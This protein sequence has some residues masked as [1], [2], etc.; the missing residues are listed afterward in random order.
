MERKLSEREIEDKIR[1]LTFIITEFG[2]AYKK[3]KRDAFRYLDKYGAIDYI[4]KCW[5]PLHCENPKNV[6]REMFDVCKK[7]GGDW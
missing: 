4:D 6:I 3:D 5:W 2:E 7:N 1:F